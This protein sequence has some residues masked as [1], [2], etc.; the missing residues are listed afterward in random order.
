M[1]LPYMAVLSYKNS[2]VRLF[3]CYFRLKI[4][5][6][7]SVNI[8]SILKKYLKN[9]TTAMDSND[10]SNKPVISHTLKHEQPDQPNTQCN[11]SDKPAQL[12]CETLFSVFVKQECCTLDGLNEYDEDFTEFTRLDNLVTHEMKR[13]KKRVIEEVF[14][15]SQPHDETKTHTELTLHQQQDEDYQ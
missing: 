12:D 8:F 4:D 13:S 2:P 7:M 3:R 10:F 6:F 1:K 11:A 15:D 9:Q 5:K 14:K